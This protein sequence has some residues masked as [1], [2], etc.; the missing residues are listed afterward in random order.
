MIG[1]TKHLSKSIKVAHHGE[2]IQEIGLPLEIVHYPR[3]YGTFHAFAKKENETPKLCLCAKDAVKI[4]ID[5][6]ASGKIKNYSD[7]LINAPL[8]SHFFPIAL[9]LWSLDNSNVEILFE[10]KICHR[11]NMMPPKLSYCLSMYGGLFRQTYGWYINQTKMRCGVIPGYEIVD[12]EKCPAEVKSIIEKYFEFIDDRNS[13][14]SSWQTFNGHNVPMPPSEKINELDLKLKQMYREISNFFENHTRQEFGLRKIGDAWI[15]ETILAQLVAKIFSEDKIIRHYRPAW[16][17]RLELDIF[18]PSQNI[19]F[20]YQGQQHYFPIKAWG[21]ED[22]LASVKERD[23]KKRI[24]C[25]KA[26][27]KLCEIKFTE[28]LSLEYI[29]NR[30]KAL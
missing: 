22:A 25:N 8:S 3:L 2:I 6:S 19:G 20:E 12:P 14:I 18:V 23:A 30:I 29:I 7:K 1:K 27:I 15:G 28:P 4:A 24:L 11:C 10:Q 5:Y 16:L 9:A 17:N 26:G 21:G 13:I